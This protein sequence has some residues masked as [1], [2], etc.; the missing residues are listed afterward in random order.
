MISLVLA[1]LLAVLPGATSVA[2]SDIDLKAYETAKNQLNPSSQAQ[3][4]LALWCEARGLQAERVKPLA[5]AVL[6]DPTNVTARGLLGL[7][8]F[9]GRWQTPAA[10]GQRLKEDEALTAK[11]AE[12][13]RRR[14]ELLRSFEKK[15][16]S[17]T[18]RVR[19]AERSTSSSVSGARHR[20]STPRPR[21]TSQR[22][23]CSTRIRS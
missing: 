10:I 2:P 20:D 1:G 7:V 12:Y 13:N 3:V 8:S 14:G 9:H 5:L 6:K 18:P 16:P 11:L 15:G 4:D 17:A 23:P 22:P 21:P 19:H